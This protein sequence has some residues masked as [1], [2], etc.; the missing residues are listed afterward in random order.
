MQDPVALIMSTAATLPFNEVR[1]EIDLPGIVLFGDPLLEKIFYNLF[2]NAV[3]H[4]VR[5]TGITVRCECE[6]DSLL[7]IV[8]DNGTGIPAEEKERIFERGMG[9]NTGLGLY[10]AREILAITGIT[11]RETGIFGKGARFEISVPAGKFR[12]TG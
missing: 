3:R 7:V 4:G 12:F 9:K 1:L 6:P 10:L 11:I 2:D 5:V 8:E